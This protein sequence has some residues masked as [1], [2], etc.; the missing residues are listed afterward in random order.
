M[1][2]HTHTHTHAHAK[3]ESSIC[4]LMN[5]EKEIRV[6]FAV[7][8]QTAKQLYSHSARQV[9]SSEGKGDILRES[10]HIYLTFVTV[11]L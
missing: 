8:F 2:T 3:S 4:E 10:D 7:A 9:L 1:H 5:K 6:G 11:L